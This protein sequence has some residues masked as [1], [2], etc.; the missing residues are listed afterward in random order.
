[1]PNTAVL[2]DLADIGNER[3]FAAE[4]FLDGHGETAVAAEHAADAGMLTQRT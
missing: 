4:D 2:V 1:M 3:E